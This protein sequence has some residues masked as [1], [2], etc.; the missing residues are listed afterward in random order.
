MK[1]IL[2]FIGI[3]VFS[4]QF[5]GCS[6]LSVSP[7]D[8]KDIVG[9]T[10]KATVIARRAQIR[11]SYA[12]V[13]SDLLEVNRGDKLDILE[14]AT[15]EKEPWYRVRAYDGDNTEGWIE[16]RNLITESSL[17]KSRKLA[18]EDKGLQRQATGQLKAASNLRL[19][20]DRT[21][22]ENI[23]L[24]LDNGSTFDIIGW[25][26]V[27]KEMDASNVDDVSKVNKDAQQKK[28]GKK[29]AEHTEEDDAPI[30]IDDRFDIWYKVRMKPDVSPAPVGW[31][32]GRQVDLQVPSDIETYETGSKEFVTWQRLEDVELTEKEKEGFK[33]AEDAMDSKASSWVVLYRENPNAPPDGS[34]PS[35]FDHI[36]VLGYDKYNEDHYTVYVS[37]EVK[38]Y[39]PL[40]VDG[41]GD[42][43]VFKVNIKNA[44][45]QLEEKQFSVTKDEKKH[46][47]VQVP[48]GIPSREDDKRNKQ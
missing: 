1:R 12:V 27:L 3:F 46:L 7:G 38:G 4:A 35:D 21:N 25:K 28:A 6:L 17:A 19:S 31:L 15:Y 48:P 20:P 26:R 13:A 34:E 37:G 11:S 39:V 30:E 14:Q 36:L 8:I 29:N 40:M 23:L 41:I 22:N 18:D 45:G 2:F 43:R 42:N 5:T 16:E 33:N 24:K 32:F 10:D 44:A 47:K 9:F